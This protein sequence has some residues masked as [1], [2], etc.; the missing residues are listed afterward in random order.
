MEATPVAKG[1]PTGMLGVI[2]PGFS[3]QEMTA[4]RR[5]YITSRG[6]KPGTDLENM[7]CRQLCNFEMGTGCLMLAARLAASGPAVLHMRLHR[8]RPS[9]PQ[10]A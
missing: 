3:P 6:W 5:H 1:Q 9:R 10:C 8:R 7:V 2:P 4:A